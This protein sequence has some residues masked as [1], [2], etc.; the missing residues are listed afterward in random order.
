MKVYSNYS[1]VS[2]DWSARKGRMYA[3]PCSKIFT[4]K[5]TVARG[6]PRVQV[7]FYKMKG[8]ELVYKNQSR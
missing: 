4:A 3:S 6:S 1:G 2:R 8:Y 7:C 5:R